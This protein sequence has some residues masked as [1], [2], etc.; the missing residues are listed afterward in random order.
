MSK[1]RWVRFMAEVELRKL[2]GQLPLSAA[3][4]SPPERVNDVGVAL[5]LDYSL[6][7]AIED[8]CIDII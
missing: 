8:F 2:P 4:R 7:K 1:C 3:P 5:M 6:A